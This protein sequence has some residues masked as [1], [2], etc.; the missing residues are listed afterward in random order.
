MYPVGA[1]FLVALR[2]PSIISVVRVTTIEGTVLSVSGGNVS[3]DSRRDTQRTCD[4]EIVPRNQS[5]SELYRL[6]MSPSTEI[7]VERGLRVN[8]V[9]VYVPL[10]VFSTENCEFNKTSGGDIKWQ[11]SDRAKKISRNRFIEPYQIAKGTPLAE[12][13]GNLLKNRWAGV[14]Y[15]FNAVSEVV[16]AQ[17]TFEA[18]ADSDP[19]Q[20]VR[21]LFADYGYDLYFNG[22]GVC[23]AK[24]IP[25]PATTTTV[26]SFGSGDTNLVLDATT[27]GSL[28]QTYNGVV[29][30]GEG[31]DVAVPVQAVVWDEDQQ[32]PTYFGY[33][34]VP[35]F[36]SSPLLTTV[37]QCQQ[38]ARSMLAKVKGSSEELS[39][40]AIV[41]PAL[42]PLDVVEINVGGT[43]VCVLDSLTIPLKASDPMTAQ[44]RET[45]R[46]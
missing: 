38:T 10:G 37:A 20:C 32:S 11:G 7:K 6:L 2:K 31:T 16:N 25:D 1:D 21:N 17:L 33:G 43:S 5:T 44:A 34:K 42:E 18:G 39:W 15:D 9:D 35:Y 24:L 3:M 29:A 36:Y 26:F 4:L 14:V 45:R 46:S 22:E 28:E 41:N 12:A 19:W 8:G 27:K 30:M 23:V 13:G 40:P